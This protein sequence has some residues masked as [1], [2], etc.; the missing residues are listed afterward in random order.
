MVRLRHIHP[1]EKEGVWSLSPRRIGHDFLHPKEE[2]VSKKGMMG[3]QK[4]MSAAKGQL[5]PWQL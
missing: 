4:W 5:R 3:R 2:S 1:E